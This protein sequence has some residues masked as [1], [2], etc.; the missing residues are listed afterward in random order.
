[1]SRA[2]LRTR[3]RAEA[4]E[5]PAGPPPTTIASKSVSTAG[6]NAVGMAEA[7]QLRAEMIRIDFIFISP[8]KSAGR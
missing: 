6:S 4:A 5:S 3:P 8:G 2:F 7:T 1:M